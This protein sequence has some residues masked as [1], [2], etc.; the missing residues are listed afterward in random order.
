MGCAYQ[1]EWGD[2]VAEA[3]EGAEKLSFKQNKH[4]SKLEKIALSVPLF[5]FALQTHMV[6]TQEMLFCFYTR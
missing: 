2:E 4:A 3:A 1:H 5:A 6:I